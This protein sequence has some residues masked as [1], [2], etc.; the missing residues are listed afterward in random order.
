MPSEDTPA[1]ESPASS[2]EDSGVFEIQEVKYSLPQ[3][4]RELQHERSQSFFAKE[5]IDQVEISKIFAQA[6]KARAKGKQH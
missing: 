4:L 5:I 3:M 6:R 2:G 1:T